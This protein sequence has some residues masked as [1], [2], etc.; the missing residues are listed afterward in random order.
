VEEARA[1]ARAS[2]KLNR[3]VQ[4]GVQ[5]TSWSK[6]H[7]AAEWIQ[8]GVLGKVVCCHGS[9]SRNN[10]RGDWNYRI[11]PGAGP[12]GKGDDHIEWKQWLGPAPAR[13]FDAERFF[14]FRKYWDYSGGIATDLHYHTLAPFHL[15]VQNDHPTRVVGMGG[16]WVHDDGREVPDTF[17]NSADYPGKY[18]IVIQSSQANATGPLTMIRGDRATML[19]GDDWEGRDMD[20]LQIV[21]E[22]PYRVEFIKKWGKEQI[23]IPGAVNEGDRK[24]VDNFYECVRSR[25]QPNCNPDLAYKVMTHIG[26]STRSY[27]EGKVFYFDPKTEQILTHAPA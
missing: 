13:A 8:T 20:H 10:P 11:Q 12:D 16:I 2:A 18:S 21:P 15:A 17:M 25:K 9:Y 23:N 26:L 22:K 19:A 6:W 1:V 7:K 27:R 5:S 14:R 3:V 4:I 24:H